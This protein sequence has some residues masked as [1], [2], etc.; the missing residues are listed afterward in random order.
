M[1]FLRI[2]P[3]LLLFSIGVF[4]SLTFINAISPLNN[5]RPELS[6]IRYIV[7]HTTEAEATSALA[8]LRKRGEIHYMI[9]RQG[10]VYKIIE[11]NRIARHSGRSLW[12]GRPR[13][14]EVSIGIEMVGFH[15]KPL[16]A[17]QERSLANLLR[18]LKNR[19]HITDE[20]ILTHSMVAYGVPNRW[21]SQAHRGRKRCG[22][23]MADPQL[24]R[25]L[26]IGPGPTGDPDLESGRLK[27][28]DPY[29]FSILYNHSVDPVQTAH[30]IYESPSSNIISKIR[31]AW[32]IAR[33]KYDDAL[34]VYTLPNKTQLR[35]DQI[36]DWNSIP[37]GTKVTFAKEATTKEETTSE[38]E[39]TQET[40]DF[41]EIGKDGD[42]AIKIAGQDFDK[43][44]TLYFLKDGRVFTGMEMRFLNP[45]LLSTLPNGTRLLLGYVYGGSVSKLRSAFSITKKRWNSPATLYRLPG[46]SGKIMTGDEVV[47]SAI[48][49]GTLIFFE[50]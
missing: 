28:A 19:Y 39:P 30:A 11:E 29:L 33:E 40:V 48:P 25:R 24:R 17:A 20:K 1:S 45:K 41:K 38:S 2:W 10:Q 7:L 8:K 34:T 47:P 3:K 43:S 13:V 42:S 26:G 46:P 15:N 21:H 22:M 35:G 32:F 5:R 4:A 44:T 16:E 18:E 9:D 6:E 49:N 31:S 23:L 50:R 37:A 36:N 12:Q 27:N 14:D